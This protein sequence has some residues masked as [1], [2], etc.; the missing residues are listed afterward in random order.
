MGGYR[1]CVIDNFLTGAS[2]QV[3][4]DIK[5]EF[6]PIKNSLLRP[7][8]KYKVTITMYLEESDGY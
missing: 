7:V 3:A 5:I 6:E 4:E 1:G 2:F 8:S